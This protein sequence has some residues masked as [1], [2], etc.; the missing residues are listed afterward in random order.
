ML[1]I[2]IKCEHVLVGA[3]EFKRLNAR[4]IEEQSAG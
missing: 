3:D 2:E 4:N 1:E